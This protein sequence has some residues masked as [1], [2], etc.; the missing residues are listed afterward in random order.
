MLA[1]IVQDMNSATVPKYSAKFRKAAAGLRDTQLLNIFENAFQILEGILTR[2]IPFESDQE[3]RT[4]DATLDLLLKCLSFDFAGTSADEASDDTGNIPT[5]WRTIYQRQDFVPSFFTAYH[6]FPSSLASKA[7]EC[8]VQIAAARKAL[9]STEEERSQFV[10][11]IMQGIRDIIL[12]SQHLSDSD[13]YN[14]FCRLLQRFRTTA[15]LNEIAEKQ[16]YMAWIELVAGFTQKAF[17]SSTDACY[18]LLSFWSRIVQSMTYYQK[19]EDMIVQK[20]Q[21]ITVELT[22]TFISAYLES[23]PTRMEEL[24]DDPLENE[25]VLI[26]S[27]SMLGQMARCQYEKSCAV[28]LDLFDPIMAHYEIFMNQANMGTMSGDELKEAMAIFEAQFAWIVYVMACFV[29]NRPPY[30]NIDEHDQADGELTTKVLLLMEINQSLVQSNPSFLS[31]KFD[32]AVIYFF[33]QFRKSYVGDTNKKE[34]YQKLNQVFGIE[35][36]SDMLNAMMRKIMTNLQV[37]GENASVIQK[38]LI[39]FDELASGYSAVKNLRKLETTSL[40]MQN[41]LSNE[42]AFFDHDKHRQNRMLYYQTLCKILFAEDSSEQEFYE[43]IKPFEVRL[44]DLSMLN[45][46]EEYQQPQ[47]QGAL[48]AIFR[49]LRGFIEPIQSR[50]NYSLFF[51]WFYPDYMPV[52][53]K[54]VQA[55]SPDSSTHVLLKFFVEFVTN[56]SQRLSLDVSSANGVLLFRDVSQILCTFGQHI[57][58]RQ[59]VDES[60]K[61]PVKYKGVAACFQMLAKCLGGKYIN[62]GVFWLYQ[63]KAIQEAFSI[64]YQMMLNIPLEDMM[65]FPKLSKAF[66]LM[67]DE[68]SAEQMMMDPDMPPEAFLYILEACEQGVESTD[69][70]VR[71]HACSVINNICTFAIQQNEKAE[72]RRHTDEKN[73]KNKPIQGLWLLNYFSQFPQVLPRLLSTLFGMILFDDNND[74][75][76]LSRPLYTLVL[77]ERDV[78]PFFASKYTNQVILQQLPERR[79]FVT[80]VILWKEVVGHSTQKTENNFLNK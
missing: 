65:N 46:M 4:K 38:S 22:R 43:F 34:V 64:M 9:F 61:Y 54:G 5:S 2:S 75:W 56:K 3:N 39:L 12:A 53:L 29:G 30:M 69:S 33:S 62:F 80:K 68:F 66:F 51:H 52:L 26:E 76:Q 45:T 50:K 10:T 27:L 24:L 6:E 44:E 48:Q 57:I 74:Q 78:G 37:W 13:C 63:D 71:T 47:V 31:Y 73:K 28:L 59:I 77:L 40:V 21:Q 32:L 36:E 19:L 16:D 7:M 70:F 11:R 15:P 41:H 1:V 60:K 72:L 23:V 49:D 17:Q 18:Y 67:L 20:L 14:G 25:D 42:F 35:E 58:T 8:L 79:E 55:L